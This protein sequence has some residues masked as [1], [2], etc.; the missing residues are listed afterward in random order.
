M[1]RTTISVDLFCGGG[2]EIKLNK[3]N[4]NIQLV[5]ILHNE[6]KIICKG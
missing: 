3:G 5:L 2:K 6:D 4:L 1:E